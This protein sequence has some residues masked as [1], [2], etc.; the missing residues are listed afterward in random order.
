MSATFWAE[1][2]WLPDRCIRFG[3]QRLLARRLR[4]EAGRTPAA[5][6]QQLQQLV[7][8]LRSSP[9]A[10][11]TELAN[12]QHY[13]V[14]AEFFQYVLGPRL[15]YS[16]GWWEGPQSDLA[17]AEEAMLRISCQRAGLQDGMRILDLGCGW[18]AL[19]LFI[20]EKYPGCHILGVSNSHRQRAAILERARR[21]QLGNV[22]IVTADAAVFDTDRTFDRVLSVEMFEHLRNYQQ[23]LRRIAGWLGAEG[24]LF[25]HVFCHRTLAYPFEVDGRNDWMARHFFTGGLMPSADLFHHF[26][27]DLRLAEQWSING[28]HYARTCEAWLRNLDR[29]AE[30]IR[31]LFRQQLTARQAALQLQRWRMFFM[32]CAEL[33]A[34]E[35]GEEWQVGHYRFVLPAHQASERRRQ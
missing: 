21:L 34:Y 12:R 23:L 1:R 15:K 17:A 35:R 7:T 2:G 31:R 33:F 18:G 16:C 19:S 5:R 28:Q 11:H 20:A 9:V 14:P 8:Q 27:D 13:E 25:V 32:A 6:Q 30:D 4:Q 22:E 3:I 24:E 10:L 29:Q 26:Q